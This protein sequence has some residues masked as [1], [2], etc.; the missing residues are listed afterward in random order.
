MGELPYLHKCDSP[1]WQS[2]KTEQKQ[3]GITK[4][5]IVLNMSKI[6]RNFLNHQTHY[7]R[8]CHFSALA[9][10]GLVPLSSSGSAF[11]CTSWKSVQK[12]YKFQYCIELTDQKCIML[13]KL[14]Y[15]GLFYR[16]PGSKLC[17]DDMLQ[18]IHQFSLDC[19]E[20]ACSMYETANYIPKAF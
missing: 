2:H 19:N 17:L 3:P 18:H 4:I 16:A 10:I 5:A 12:F 1:P 6:C 7:V 14:L 15:I 20:T 11:I 13:A 8:S 9:H